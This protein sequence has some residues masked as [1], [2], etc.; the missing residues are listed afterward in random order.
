MENIEF[1]KLMM[2]SVTLII[3]V[4]V[5]LKGLAEYRKKTQLD[6]ANIF[7]ELR[8]KFKE[9]ENFSLIIAHLD[10]LDPALEEVSKS[11]RLKF[12]GFLEEVA[13][14]N[15]S[16]LLDDK[17]MNQAFGYYVIKVFE[18]PSMWWEGNQPDSEYRLLLVWMKKV[19]E[20]AH[21]REESM[22][23]GTYKF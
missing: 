6:R 3:A 19:C 21:L 20:E 13:L 18:H 23:P 8:Q 22:Y 4:V 12:L 14:M 10:A 16:G 17:I 9:T 11:D 5:L 15:N 1:A 7:L 2:Q